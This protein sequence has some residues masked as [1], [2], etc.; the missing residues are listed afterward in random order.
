MTPRTRMWIQLGGA[1]F[2][3][4]LAVAELTGLKSPT[5]GLGWGP[6]IFAACCAV[7]LFEAWRSWRKCDGTKETAN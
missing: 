6:Y 1:A 2:F 5:F 7:M 4:A 3:V